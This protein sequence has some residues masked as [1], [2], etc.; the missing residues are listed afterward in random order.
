[1]L[2]GF[3][4]RIIG[5]FSKRIVKYYTTFYIK[6]ESSQISDYLCNKTTFCF[7]YSYWNQETAL[8]LSLRIRRGTLPICEQYVMYYVTTDEAVVLLRPG[9]FLYYPVS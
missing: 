1:M 8:R 6:L 3:I 7:F 4:S 2:I 5:L 9:L